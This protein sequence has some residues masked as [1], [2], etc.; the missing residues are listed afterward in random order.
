MI[1]KFKLKNRFN[2]VFVIDKEAEEWYMLSENHNQYIKGKFPD[3]ME[4]THL[5]FSIRSNDY[6]LVIDPDDGHDHWESWS[7]FDE[8]AQTY[9]D[10]GGEL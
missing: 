7:I 8:K 10:I 1:H 5:P 6:S 2:V 3:T 9:L 4:R